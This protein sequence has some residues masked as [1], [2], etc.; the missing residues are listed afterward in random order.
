MWRGRFDAEQKNHQPYLTEAYE[1]DYE[2]RLYNS[3][4]I[5]QRNIWDNNTVIRDV[6]PRKKMFSQTKSDLS[7]TTQKKPNPLGSTSGSRT[8]A[9]TY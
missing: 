2:V 3:I 8:L 1:Y 7:I 5:F 9:T 6:R 4:L